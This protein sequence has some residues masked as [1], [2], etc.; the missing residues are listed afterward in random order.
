MNCAIYCRFS[1]KDQEKG[2]SIEAQED[3]CRAFAKSRGWTITHMYVD[4]ARS[5]TSDKRDEFQR[6]ISDVIESQENPFDALIV[7]K[8]N[9][10]ARNRADAVKYKFMLR[11]K[12][13]EIISATQPFMKNSSPEDIIIESMMEGIDEWKSYD[14]A[15]EALK[16]MTQNAK[17]G[18]MNGGRPPYGFD[19]ENV[20][21]EG[22]PKKKL[23]INEIEAETVKRIYSL[24]AEY[25]IG[26]KEIANKLNSEKL[27]K[28]DGRPW[29]KKTIRVI[30][31]NEK[32]VGDTLLGKGRSQSKTLSYRYIKEP[33]RVENT[34][35]GIVSRDLF[36]KAQSLLAAKTSGKNQPVLTGS[37]YLLSGRI[38][39]G[40]CGARFV[41]TSAKS[42]KHLYYTCGTRMRSGNSAC[43]E[44]RIKKNDIETK[45][46][47]IIRDS[48]LTKEN[49]KKAAIEIH[50]SL[51]A[52][53]R[54]R[55]REL[56]HALKE[57]DKAEK[58]LNK[59]YLIMENSEQITFD[60]LAPRIR[61]LKSNIADSEVLIR[62]IQHQI[63]ARKNQ[64][65]SNE[66]CIK[67]YVEFIVDFFQDEK[68]FSKKSIIA[69]TIE[70]ITVKDGQFFFRCKI[71][72]DSLIDMRTYGG[73]SPTPILKDKYR[74]IAEIL[75]HQKIQKFT[76]SI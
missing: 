70:S 10:F 43:N 19:S 60:D 26:F 75:S 15:T 41:G 22:K 45:A 62:Q 61:E 55:E 17:R 46:K 14:I 8:S 67:G 31:T 53:E 1:S 24:Y 27:K 37:Q 48:L 28:R 47:D 13:V 32:N 39:C 16:G 25:G 63:D 6:M 4:R 71:P 76:S 42:G 59:L 5:G 74:Q 44:I 33:L 58:S 54:L 11:R 7:H 52:K 20:T 66:D 9:R 56:R 65:M 40:N 57:K 64:K 73:K 35:K 3:E 34:H 51:K 29:D 68:L 50:E 18:F 12:G 2:F 30:I 36:N 23:K 72:L 69:D 21:F 38:I 49:I